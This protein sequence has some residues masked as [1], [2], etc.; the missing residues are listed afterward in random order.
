MVNPLPSLSFSFSLLLMVLEVEPRPSN[1]LG[2]VSPLRSAPALSY[3]VLE[4][5]QALRTGHLDWSVFLHWAVRQFLWTAITQ[6]H[7]VGGLRQQRS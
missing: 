1:V 3:E 5:T 2:I 4:T 6:D 7:K